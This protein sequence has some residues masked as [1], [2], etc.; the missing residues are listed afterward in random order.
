MTTKTHNKMNKF[1]VE[2]RERAVR[3]VQD[4]WGEYPSLAAGAFPGSHA[5]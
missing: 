3:L 5:G 1:S 2:V 4:H